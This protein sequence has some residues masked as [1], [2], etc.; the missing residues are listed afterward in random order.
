MLPLPCGDITSAISTSSIKGCPDTRD[1]HY[2]C[3]L[4]NPSG[5]AIF[6]TAF[7]LLPRRGQEVRRDEFATSPA[8]FRKVSEKIPPTWAGH[9]GFALVAKLLKFNT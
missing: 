2:R 7:H 4:R 9:G 8:S 6:L 5:Y 1:I 3:G